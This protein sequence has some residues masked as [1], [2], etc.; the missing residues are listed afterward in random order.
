[1]DEEGECSPVDGSSDRGVTPL[2]TSESS[3]EETL[4]TTSQL[5]TTE[6]GL[7]TVVPL[8][9]ESH[10]TGS[11][12][13]TGPS[14]LETATCLPTVT[15][16]SPHEAEPELVPGPVIALD[17]EETGFGPGYEHPFMSLLYEAGYRKW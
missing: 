3:R 1:M 15:G 17:T 8:V 13:G 9:T 7:N 4:T 2:I 11:G 16:Y 12:T 10:Q 5:V 6:D 14:A